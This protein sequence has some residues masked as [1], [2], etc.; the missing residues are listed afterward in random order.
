VSAREY[1][2]VELR[3]TYRYDS[4]LPYRIW[5]LKHDLPE[6]AIGLAWQEDVDGPPHA[7][8]GDELREDRDD[9][10]N[11]FRLQRDDVVVAWPEWW[12]IS[13]LFGGVK[14]PWPRRRK[15][16]R[17]SIVEAVGRGLRRAL[18]VADPDEPTPHQQLVEAIREGVRAGV[19]GTAADPAVKLM[20]E[21]IPYGLGAQLYGCGVYGSVFVVESDI[22]GTP[23]RHGDLLLHAHN[24]R[25]GK[26]VH[27]HADKPRISR[28]DFPALIEGRDALRF[29]AS[30]WQE[31][32]PSEA[33]DSLRRTAQHIVNRATATGVWAPDDTS[34]MILLRPYARP[35]ADAEGHALLSV[36]IPGGIGRIG[37]PESKGWLDDERWCGRVF[38]ATRGIDGAPVRANDLILFNPS[39]QLTADDRAAM[40]GYVAPV[41]RACFPAIVENLAALVWVTDS[42][43]GRY[44]NEDPKE[45]YDRL[46]K[47]LKLAYRAT[48][49]RDAVCDNRTS[50]LLILREHAPAVSV[51]VQAATDNEA[52]FHLLGH[53]GGKLPSQRGAR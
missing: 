13:D 24:G 21:L 46:R 36:L 42:W 31:I 48:K 37:R 29:L 9:R 20:N 52:L 16:R 25:S 26:L 18:G 43:A 30:A 17:D 10:S 39:H 8:A 28:R 2:G 4:G 45:P 47:G 6:L 40:H 50:S 1:P 14:P 41:P 35:A 53:V 7:I 23:A 22:P 3:G 12:Q 38:R 34:P 19:Q 33:A 15:D 44:E 51:P 27:V 5:T 32:E 49:R 11:L